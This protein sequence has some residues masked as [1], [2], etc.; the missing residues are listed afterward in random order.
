M[1]EPSKHGTGGLTISNLEHYF[2]NLLYY[3]EDRVEEP[4]KKAL[5]EQEQK[6]VEE[7]A[8]YVLYSI[9]SNREEFLTWVR[10]YE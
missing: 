7:C 4:N 5:T 2:E 8:N 10:R 9:F 3:G 1:I 6:I